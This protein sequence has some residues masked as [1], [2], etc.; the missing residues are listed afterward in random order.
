MTPPKPRQDYLTALKREVQELSVLN[1]ISQAIN[2]SLNLEVVMKNIMEVL[3]EKMGM[4]RGT[5]SLLNSRTGDL[6]IEVAHGLEKEAERL[7]A[8]PHPHAVAEK[9]A[10]DDVP[11]M[12]ETMWTSAGA[13]QPSVDSQKMLA[14][15]KGSP[16]GGIAK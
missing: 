10:E 9:T 15:G 13:Q 12:E 4:E 14:P 3:H 5:L 6:L 16:F 11:S 8:K 1:E 2:S 7:I